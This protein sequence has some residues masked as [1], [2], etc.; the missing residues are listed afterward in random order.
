MPCSSFVVSGDSA[1]GRRAETGS[2]TWHPD[3]GIGPSPAC[4][5]AP[6]CETRYKAA[7]SLGL[8]L[9]PV[10][11]IPARQARAFRVI[12]NRTSEMTSWDHDLLPH[13]LAGLD[14]LDV[15]SFDDILPPAATAGK[16]DPDDIPETPKNPVTRKG[17]IW[18]LG[19]HRIVCGDSTDQKTVER[20]LD[21]AKPDLMVT[22]PPYGV[23]Y[24]STWRWTTGISTRGIATGKSTNDDTSDWQAAYALF[25]GSIA[26]V[27]M[28]SLA[29]PVA[30]GGLAACGFIPRS[31]IIWDKGHI[32]IGRGHYHWRH[33]TCWY[34]VKKGAQANWKGDRKAS[35][36][37]EI[38]NPLKSET[39]H[40]AQ[41]P[42][43]CMQ[44]AIHNHR[45]DVCVKTIT[46]ALNRIKR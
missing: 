1:T 22:D 40:S 24:D 32:V 9:A 12:D 6:A 31:L 19:T 17:D 5:G 41:K 37:W 35:T 14:D 2:G 45:G 34:A 44:R 18:L 46:Y 23:N 10:V 20:L 28:S 15:F 25:P 29:L 11:T 21:G 43:E 33:E 13:A 3:V 8:T 36:L 7:L 42:V 16:T 26:Y 27:W 39:G 30:A 38:D 4:A